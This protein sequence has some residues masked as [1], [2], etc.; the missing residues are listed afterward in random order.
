M[1]GIFDASSGITILGP[2]VDLRNNNFKNMITDLNSLP[3]N[4]PLSF[5]VIIL[6]VSLV[7]V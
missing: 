2:T 7:T 5:L 4:G 1:L 6:V 3:A